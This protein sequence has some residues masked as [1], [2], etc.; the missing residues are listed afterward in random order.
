MKRRFFHFLILAFIALSTTSCRNISEDDKSNKK[1]LLVS[2]TV[3]EDIV[4]NIVG[5]EFNVKSITTVSYTHLR[6]HET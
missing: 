1:L 2:F 3:L 4:K 6:A 5:E